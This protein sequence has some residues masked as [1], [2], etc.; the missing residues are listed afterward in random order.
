MGFPVSAPQHR[1]LT[2]VNPKTF[3][4]HKKLAFLKKKNDD[5]RPPLFAV[6]DFQLNWRYV[7]CLRPLL[8]LFDREGYRLPL[9]EGLKTIDVDSAEVDKIVFSVL[10]G[11]KPI[12]LGVVEPFHCSLSQSVAS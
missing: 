7:R 9:V 5:Q 8:A 11:D 6:R 10:A 1:K 4:I 2:G 12:A 3:M